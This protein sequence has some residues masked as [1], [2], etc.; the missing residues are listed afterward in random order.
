MKFDLMLTGVGGEGVLTSG[1]IIAR[2]ANLEGYYVRGVQLHGLAQRGGTIPT[3]V[4]FGDEK[5]LSSPGIMQANADLVMAFEPME[6]VRAV[7]YARK[8][9]TN[10]II[11]DHPH[12]PIYANL[13]DVPYPKMKLISGKIKP[14]AK[15]I[16]V[17]GAHELAKKEFNDTIFGNLILIGAAVGSNLLPLKEKNLK[18]AIKATVP[19]ETEKNLRAFD[20]GIRLGKKR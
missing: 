1:V 15:G 16:Q 10:F 4:R 7:F 18:E 9:K 3:F 14:F 5:E 6:A 17:F 13:L 12:M 20:L 2:A 11:N 8:D 19:V